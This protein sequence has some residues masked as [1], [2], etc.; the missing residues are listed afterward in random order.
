MYLL[1]LKNVS[2]PEDTT[3]M[4]P[5]F[6]MGIME[7]NEEVEKASKDTQTAIRLLEE[8]KEAVTNLTK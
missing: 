5:E 4:D 2:L 6:L 1:E 8:N 3:D 7:K